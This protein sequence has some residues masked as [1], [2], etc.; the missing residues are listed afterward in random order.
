MVAQTEVLNKRNFEYVW[1]IQGTPKFWG[2]PLAQGHA[3]FSSAWNFMI[4][5]A[6][7]EVPG[8]IYY[9][10]IKKWFLKFGT[11][12]TG[13]TPYYLEK[14]TLLLDSQ[15]Q[16]FLFD[17]QL[18]WSYDYSKWEIFYEKPHFTI[19]NFKFRGGAVKWGLK[20]FAHLYAKSSRTNRLAYVAVTFLWRYRLSDEKKSTRESLLE[21][22]C[23]L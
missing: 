6:K 20:I 12:Q 10:N 22:R 17:V 16:C 8:F 15:I 11:N 21:T 18:L 19:K 9:G 7:L 23:R 1:H 5:L 14:M 2:A 4:G 13:E 3:H